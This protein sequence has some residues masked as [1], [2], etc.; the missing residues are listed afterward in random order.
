[1]PGA[2]PVPSSA[3]ADAACTQPAVNASSCAPLPKYAQQRQAGSCPEVYSVRS[4]GARLS[5]YS[6]N[7]GGCMPRSDANSTY[8]ATGDEVPPQT[9]PVIEVSDEPAGRL[10]RRSQSLPRSRRRICQS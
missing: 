9:F 1:V 10:R 5:T 2:A 7:D 3:F 6:T 4:L 8:Y